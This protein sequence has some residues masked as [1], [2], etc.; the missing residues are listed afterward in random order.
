MARTLVSYY[1]D[2]EEWSQELALEQEAIRDKNMAAWESLMGDY[3]SLVSMD[4]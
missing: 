3:D 2:K 4:N 1:L